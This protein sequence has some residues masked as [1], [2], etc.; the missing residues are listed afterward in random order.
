MITYGVLSG[1]GVSDRS[2]ASVH[3]GAEK[4]GLD[5]KSLKDLIPDEHRHFLDTL[6]TQA[7]V[8]EL[9]EYRTSSNTE[10]GLRFSQKQAKGVVDIAFAHKPKF[11]VSVRPE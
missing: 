9:V 3:V 7:G 8:P 11:L 10:R 1:T 5:Q 2:H 6:L 4:G